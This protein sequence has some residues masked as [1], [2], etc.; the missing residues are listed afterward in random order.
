MLNVYY[1]YDII[2]SERFDSINIEN[3]MIF[4]GASYN[5]YKRVPLRVHFSLLFIFCC[6]VS[7]HAG[8]TIQNTTNV[9]LNGY[10][11]K[12]ISD[13]EQHITRSVSDKRKQSL[14]EHNKNEHLSQA[15]LFQLAKMWDVLSNT[16]RNAYLSLSI[17][18]DSASVYTTPGSHFEIYFKPTHVASHLNG[19]N[20]GF[21]NNSWRTKQFTPNGIP[22][23]IDEIGWALDSCWELEVNKLQFIAPIPYKDDVFKSDKYK[24]VAFNSPDYGYTYPFPAPDTARYPKGWASIIDISTNWTALNYDSN[25]LDAIRVTCAHE[26]FHSIQFSMTWNVNDNT[27]LML[28]DYPLAWLEGTATSLEELAFPSV[29]DYLHYAPFYF[30]TPDRPFLHDKDVMSGFLY[31]N[32]LLMLYISK[33]ISPSASEFTRSILFDNYAKPMPFYANIRSVSKKF[34]T[35]WTDLLHDFHVASFFSGKYADSSRFLSD[36]QM[37]DTIV[38]PEDSIDSCQPIV[39]KINPYAMKTYSLRNSNA[40][41]IDSVR[42]I[43]NQYNQY[44]NSAADIPWKA[45][46]LRIRSTIDTAIAVS[47]DK[48]GYGTCTVYSILPD[49]RIIAVVTNGQELETKDYSVLFNTCPDKYF[50]SDTLRLSVFAAESQ[51]SAAAVFKL[52]T[53]ILPCNPSLGI[54]SGKIY[55]EKASS[56]SLLL[57]SAPFAYS[58]PYLWQNKSSCTFAISVKQT[59]GADYSV[60]KWNDLKQLW[61]KTIGF[62]NKLTGELNTFTVNNPVSGTYAIGSIIPNVTLSVYPNPVSLGNGSVFFSGKTIKTIAIYDASGQ[63]ILNKTRE[64]TIPYQWNLRTKFNKLIVP[65]IYYAIISHETGFNERDIY[66]QKIMVTP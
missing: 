46:L 55:T 4:A 30:S 20:Y 35:Y 60:Y 18:P 56:M 24:V 34:D 6:Y 7:I 58:V 40:V 21:N 36:A 53:T 29:N 57:H 15:D 49:E 38:V 3:T 23:Y 8:K 52:D 16:T 33:I 26:F 28:D 64:I 44:S 48:N 9:N 42:L 22:D 1:Y 19:D 66:K 37:F 10:S 14:S 39:K 45:S 12:S 59:Q 62:A 31:A 25:P 54:A 17:I 61:E 51:S 27:T 47:L 41:T 43:F 32:S 11:F 5:R 50:T 63:L 65:G 13:F 2:D